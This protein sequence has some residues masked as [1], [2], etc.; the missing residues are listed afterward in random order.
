VNRTGPAPNL[1]GEA[2]T[3]EFVIR[4]DTLSGFGGLARETAVP[5]ELPQPASATAA[6]ARVTA[7]QIRTS[8]DLLSGGGPSGETAMKPP[9]TLSGGRT[10]AGPGRPGASDR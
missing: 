6:A 4:T 1:A 8:Q 7:G 9:A 2:I 5:P 3:R 10:N